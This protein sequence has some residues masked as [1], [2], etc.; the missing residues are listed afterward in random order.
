M[1]A[2][3]VP[4]SSSLGNPLDKLQLRDEDVLQHIVR[5]EINQNAAKEV[6]KNS[7]GDLSGIAGL[8]FKM[9]LRNSAR[10]KQAGER[11]L[12]YQTGMKR[13]RDVA[14]QAVEN[15]SFAVALKEQLRFTKDILKAQR[16][17]HG[18]V[19]AGMTKATELVEDFNERGSA[20]EDVLDSV[21]GM[22]DTLA[23]DRFSDSEQ[24][25]LTNILRDL[26]IA[27]EEGEDIISG[28]SDGNGWK[29]GGAYF[30]PTPPSTNIGGGI[31]KS[32][33]EYRK[34]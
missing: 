29:D 6:I 14:N 31:C 9:F 19:M 8:R 11:K 3:D 21:Q 20:I 23:D 27:E 15:F 7:K 13:T 25:V 12:R 32:S 22:D 33:K 28:L 16:H 34:T 10:A 24:A 17:E 5:A 2:Q 1:A 18:D 26:H 4:K 30:L